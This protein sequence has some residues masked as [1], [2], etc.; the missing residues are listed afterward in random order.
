MIKFISILFF[1]A[2]IAV[3]L[4]V[5]KK[6][7]KEEQYYDKFYFIVSKH[8]TLN[9]YLSILSRIKSLTTGLYDY[10]G[11]VINKR[12]AHTEYHQL[13]VSAGYYQLGQAIRFYVMAVVCLLALEITAIILYLNGSVQIFVIPASM[14]I[15]YIGSKIY[16]ERKHKKE[17]HNFRVNFIYFLDLSAACIKTG[18]TL[19]ASLE[20]LHPIVGNFSGLLGIAMSN[21]SQNIKYGNIDDASNKLYEQ[22]PLAEVKDFISTVKNSLKYGSSMATSLNELSQEIRKTHFIETEEKIGSVNAKMGIPLI[23]FIMFPIIVEIIAPGLLRA[24]SEFTL[25]G[26]VK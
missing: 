9:N 2:G 5:I 18:M 13:V 3:F 20:T 22:V 4:F 12:L 19:T 17:M 11:E 25:G 21:Y 1:I 23:L 26:I 10:V 24:V 8:Q 6:H 7:R 16:L 14:A 15:Y